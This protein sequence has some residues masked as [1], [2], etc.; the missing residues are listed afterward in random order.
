[1]ERALLFGTNVELIDG[2]AKLA[3]FNVDPESWQVD[4]LVL[5]RGFFLSGQT[6]RAPAGAIVA[7]ARTLRLDTA[8]VDC[9]RVE[10]LHQHTLLRPTSRVHFMDLSGLTRVRADLLGALIDDGTRC[11]QLVVALHGRWLLVPAEAVR[12]QN[13]EWLYVD[14]VRCPIDSLAE[15]GAVAGAGA[16]VGPGPGGAEA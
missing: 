1:M 15:Y 10:P 3:G 12:L 5:E 6:R 13:E 7:T 8:F 2:L 4:W 9:D 11:R 16:V 14:I